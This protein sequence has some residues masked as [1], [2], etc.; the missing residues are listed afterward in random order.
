MTNEK[1]ELKKAPD[2]KERTEGTYI[3]NADSGQWSMRLRQ[4][5]HIATRTETESFAYFKWHNAEVLL[6][7]ILVKFG[8]FAP[9]INTS[10]AQT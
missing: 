1:K 7:Y 4:R 2:E 6:Q 3:R 5:L 9:F 10:A 8:Y